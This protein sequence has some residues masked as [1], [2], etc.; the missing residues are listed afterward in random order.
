MICTR[1]LEILVKSQ[2]AAINDGITSGGN[3][4]SAEITALRCLDTCKLAAILG[5]LGLN[6]NTK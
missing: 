4:F 2:G 6:E 5:Q 3:H 1:L